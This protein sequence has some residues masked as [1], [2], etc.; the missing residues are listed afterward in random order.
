MPCC[1]TL[2]QQSSV[3]LELA[4]AV[5]PLK[6]LVAAAAAAQAAAGEQQQLPTLFLDADAQLEAP[7]AEADGSG[8]LEVG[9]SRGWARSASEAQRQQLLRELRDLVT[10]EVSAAAQQILAQQVQLL[11][12]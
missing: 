11:C 2:A 10:A 3:R 7:S 8:T 6:Q 9:G 5:E 1:D 4:A 12:D